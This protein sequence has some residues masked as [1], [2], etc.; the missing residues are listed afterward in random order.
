MSVSLVPIA[1]MRRLSTS[2]DCPT[3]WRTLSATAASVSVS[4][5]P[6]AVCVTSSVRPFPAASGP[7][8][9][10][11]SDCRS[12]NALARSAGSAMRTRTPRGSTAMPPEM[13]ILPSRIFCRT[14]SRS[15]STWLLITEGVSTSIRR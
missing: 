1:L 11:L 15:A 4:R 5:T 6:S 2:I 7:P 13:A 10:W 14:S 3:A 12:S 8:I 9:G